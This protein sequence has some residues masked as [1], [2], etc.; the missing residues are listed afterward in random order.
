MTFWD[1]MLLGACGAFCIRL[2]KLVHELLHG[3]AQFLHQ[4]GDFLVGCAL[5]CSASA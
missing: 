5:F 2:G 1:C 4:L 3:F